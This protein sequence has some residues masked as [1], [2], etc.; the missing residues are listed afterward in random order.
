MAKLIS[1]TPQL[2]QLSFGFVNAFL[3]E[4]KGFTLV[5]TGYKN[6][7]YT[8]F[9]A[10][11]EAGKDPYRIKQV[12]LTHCHPDHAGSAAAVNRK[13]NIPVYA[14]RAEKPLLEAGVSGRPCRRSPG[15]V[16]W[17]VY[18]T[19]IKNADKT[20]EPVQVEESLNDGDELPG[21]GGLRVL[22]T[23]GHSAGHI[24]LLLR[25][26]GLLIAG[27][28]CA[29]VSGLGLSAVY[30]NRATGIQSIEKAAR[31]DFDKA[32]FGHGKPICQH[33][34]RLMRQYA[35]EKLAGLY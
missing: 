33:G 34:D 8:I 31:S 21:A 6:S 30:E 28:I 22:H 14:H 7:L 11:S 3:I 26:E 23:P 5:D 25:Q 29:H 16:N 17:I 12:I 4:D 10:I 24:S 2:S 18:T 35:K 15:L 27:D 1:I 20:N 32:V 13:L 9:K 19:F